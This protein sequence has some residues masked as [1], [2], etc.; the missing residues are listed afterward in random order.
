MTVERI[1]TE[2][3]A[4]AGVGTPAERRRRA[5]DLLARV[6]LNDQMLQRYP[7]EFSGGQR[8][9]IVVARALM[10]EPRLVICDEPVSA[11]DVSVQAQ[12]LNLLKELQA[13]FGFTYLFI[14]HDLSVVDYVSDRIMV[15]Y[16]GRIVE[17][18]TPDQLYMQPRHPYTEALM[19]SI[20]TPDPRARKRESPPSGGVPNPAAPPP[21]CHFHPRCT[22]A[23]DACRQIDPVLKSVDE[24]DQ[25]RRAACIR[26]DELSLKG[27]RDLRTDGDR[28][29]R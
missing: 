28:A 19:A 24:A 5:Q 26:S 10:L 4:I 18:G 29:A 15:M 1:L 14:A 17:S 9:R 12:V 6:G 27:Y 23:V 16:L 13:D 8:Q 21:G 25:A 7:N 22:Y 3:L 2:P 11:L 20:P